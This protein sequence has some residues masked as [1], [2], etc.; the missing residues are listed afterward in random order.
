MLETMVFRSCR[1]DNLPHDVL[2]F[3]H[4]IFRH[5]DARAG[6]GFHVDHKLP[7]VRPRKKGKSNERVEKKTQHKQS[8]ESV[9]GFARPVQRLPDP[10]LV[11]IQQLLEFCVEPEVKSSP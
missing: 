11:K 6:R 10:A 5:L 8:A 7:R 4:V 2:D 3:L 1:R 9:E